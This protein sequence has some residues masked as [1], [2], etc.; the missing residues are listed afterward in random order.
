[1]PDPPSPEEFK[2]QL[3]DE[4]ASNLKTL[5]KQK[6]EMKSLEKDIVKDKTAQQDLLSN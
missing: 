6:E 1:M 5:Y 3:K 4:L 2:V